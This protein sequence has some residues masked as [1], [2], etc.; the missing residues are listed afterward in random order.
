MKVS[1][2]FDGTLQL[3]EVQRYAQELIEKGIEP[4]ITTTRWDE[5]HIH[6]YAEI[7]NSQVLNHNDLYTIAETL[8][9]PK[10]HIWFTNM[11]YKA[12]YLKDKD[13]KWHLDDN[14]DEIQLMIEIGCKVPGVCYSFPGWKE[15]CDTIISKHL[16]NE[17]IP[18]DSGTHSGDVPTGC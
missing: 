14:P 1:F 17:K 11:Q 7:G 3:S 12:N 5:E 4:W 16:N 2:D 13:F 8:N 18:T 9:I 10:E 6:K 15:I